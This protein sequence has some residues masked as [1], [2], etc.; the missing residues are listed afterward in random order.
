MRWQVLIPIS[1]IVSSC[2][3]FSVIWWASQRRKERESFYRYE[4]SRLML[5][6]Y[7]DDRDRVFAWLRWQEANDIARRRDTLRA[8]AWVLLLGGV[9]VLAGIGFRRIDEALFGYV[10]IGVGFGI[11]TY[12]LTSRPSPSAPSPAPPRPAGE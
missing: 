9:G 12:L 4:L 1:S 3:A 6:K 5:D 7:A 11:F 8:I 2:L 10:P